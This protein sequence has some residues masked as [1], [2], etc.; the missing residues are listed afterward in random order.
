VPY[1][2]DVPAAPGSPAPVTAPSEAVTGL[3]RA[4]LSA[5]GLPASE[6]EFELLASAYP[7]L[8][9]AADRLQ[10]IAGDS[11]PAPVFDPV[12]LFTAAPGA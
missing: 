8:R 10:A 6:A 1:L 11:D 3:V 7:A 12:R 4:L 9:A 5:A 2:S